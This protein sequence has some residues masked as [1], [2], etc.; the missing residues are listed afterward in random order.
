M[1]QQRLAFDPVYLSD[2]TGGQY[3]DLLDLAQLIVSHA[4]TN[5]L[6]PILALGLRSS[7]NFDFVTLGLYDSRTENIR[8]D[9]WK[10]G[11]VQKRRESI[12]VFTCASGWA[13]KNQRSV[14][15]QNLDTEPKLPVFL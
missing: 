10:A 2:L 1:P 3:R 11:H 8:L 13:W 5:A 4:T 6:F 15:I 12:P 14:L 7:L 9:T